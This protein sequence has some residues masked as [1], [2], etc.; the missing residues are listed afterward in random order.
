MKSMKTRSLSVKAPKQHRSKKS[1]E[2][3]ISAAKM[4]VVNDGITAVSTRNLSKVSEMSVGSIYQYFPNKHSVILCLYTEWLGEFTCLFENAFGRIDYYEN[5]DRWYESLVDDVFFLMKNESIEETKFGSEMITAN[6]I[7]PE[8]LNVDQEHRDQA[9]NYLM[10]ALEFFGIKHS[11]DQKLFFEYLY[12]LILSFD[13]IN[14]RIS[15][16]EIVDLHKSV[17]LTALK[18]HAR[19]NR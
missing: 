9:I 10:S 6:S 16:K 14:E 2:R 1:V 4:L 3:I 17:V 13:A 5:I 18:E 7:Y 15:G 8:L 12:E 19:L 11:C